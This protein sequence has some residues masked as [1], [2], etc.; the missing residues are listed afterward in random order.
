MG[1]F[2][3]LR[4]LTRVEKR[5]LARA[6]FWLP[7]TAIMLRLIGYQRTLAIYDRD[8]TT[9]HSRTVTDRDEDAARTVAR[10][11]NIAANHGFY[12]ARCLVKS[13]VLLKFLNQCSIPCN[14]VLGTSIQNNGF[15]AHAWVE[16]N[17]IVINDVADVRRRYK[18]FVSP[19]DRP[20]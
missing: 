19:T 9:P 15:S 14:V 3:Q 7:T 11:V 4:A 17:G 13:L 10:V 5:Y 16:C 6:A 2:E 20:A 1:R 12:R 8:K 18:T